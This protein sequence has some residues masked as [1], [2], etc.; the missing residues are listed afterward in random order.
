M[1][2]H[3][4]GDPRRCSGPNI[5]MLV[6]TP[7]FCSQAFVMLIGAIFTWFWVPDPCDISGNPR[8]LEDLGHGKQ[9]RKAMKRAEKQARA[10]SQ[11]RIHRE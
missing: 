8:S 2:A 9:A 1:G 7:H 5:K 11:S 6:L 3:N 4:V 10:E